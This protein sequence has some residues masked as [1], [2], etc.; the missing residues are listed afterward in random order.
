MSVELTVIIQEHNEAV[1]YVHHMIS[2]VSLLPYDKELI[3]VTS[4]KFRDFYSKFGRLD[5]Y[6]FPVSVIG[7]IQSCGAAR[8]NGG[9]AASGDTLLFMD[10]HVCFPPS[11]VDRLL[12]TLNAHPDAVVAPAIQPIDFPSCKIEG[13]LAHGVAFRFSEGKPFEWV[14][15][16]ADRTDREFPVP[17][18]CGCAFSM[19]KSTFNVLN[20]MGGFL[21]GHMGLSFE[22]EAT[23]RLWR[24]GNP[25]YIEPRAVFG[26]LF[27]GY[28]NKPQWDN[29][30]KSGY[31]MTRAAGLYVNIF[32]RDL[33]NQIEPILIKAWG[34]E[35]F[36]N[37]E[38][39]KTNFRWLKAKMQP[40]ANRIDERYFFRVE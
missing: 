5:N 30:Q 13:G 28:Q 40:Y 18:V 32:D 17:F 8:N 7:N 36:K 39:A 27:K 6:K 37:M 15:L 9:S 26:H 4:S 23:M 29:H 12:Q 34:N 31:Y 3:F 1:S 24:M 19:K 22:E 25:A 10:A 16:P 33:W 21:A 2:Q 20:S 38:W 35:Y 14:W 11:A